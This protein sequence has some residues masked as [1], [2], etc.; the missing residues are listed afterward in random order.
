[1]QVVVLRYWN[2]DSLEGSCIGAREHQ[3]GKFW[4]IL[5]LPERKKAFE[6]AK[7]LL[8]MLPWASLTSDHLV[9]WVTSQLMTGHEFRKILK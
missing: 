7:S 5:L 4:I 1:M 9:R 2:Q 3:D 8:K 6:D